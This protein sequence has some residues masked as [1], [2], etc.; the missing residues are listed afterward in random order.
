MLRGIALG[1][2]FS[3][4]D[5]SGLCFDLVPSLSQKYY[6]ERYSKGG[7]VKKWAITPQIKKKEKFF[8][9]AG[10]MV[11]QQWSAEFLLTKYLLV[12]PDA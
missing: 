6:M 7:T 4:T 12:P 1:G 2:G 3:V 8:V 9:R 5:F 10:D 11:P